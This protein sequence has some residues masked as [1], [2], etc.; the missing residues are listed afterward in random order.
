VESPAEEK[1]VAICEDRK[2]E[3]WKEEVRCKERVLEKP[4]IIVEVESG[5]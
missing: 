1:I 2:K 4:R 5:R 3:D